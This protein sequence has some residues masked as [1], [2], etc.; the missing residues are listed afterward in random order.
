MVLRKVGMERPVGLEGG[1]E[2][3]TA[4]MMNGYPGKF[5]PVTEGKDKERGR[6]G[7]RDLS[8]CRGSG[9]LRTGGEW[10]LGLEFCI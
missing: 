3:W 9:L 7:G 5:P 2:T 6:E 4:G 10:R 1:D 8:L